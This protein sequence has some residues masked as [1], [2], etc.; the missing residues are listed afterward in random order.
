MVIAYTSHQLRQVCQLSTKSL[1]RVSREIYYNLKQLDICYGIPTHIGTT[2]GRCRL[3]APKESSPIVTTTRNSVV[4]Q[5][6]VNNAN[7]IILSSSIV[8]SSE[9]HN[10]SATAPNCSDRSLT[11]AVTC[12]LLSTRSVCKVSSRYSY[13]PL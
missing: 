12:V 7:L 3:R 1:M 4:K 6:D 8:T 13:F 11:N 10:G 9:S 2:G 5:T